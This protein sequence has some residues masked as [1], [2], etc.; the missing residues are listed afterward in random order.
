MSFLTEELQV[1]E[2]IVVV[3]AASTH[4]FFQVFLSLNIPSPTAVFSSDNK[5]IWHMTLVT[6]A[7]PTCEGSRSHLRADFIPLQSE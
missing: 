7:A 1:T 4:F 2:Q 3:G 6:V 5:S